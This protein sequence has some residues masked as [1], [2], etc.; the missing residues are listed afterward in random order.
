MKEL[1]FLIDVALIACGA[2]VGWELS[3]SPEIQLFKLYAIVG[4][5]F[6]IV[7]VL[8][9]TYLVSAN[10]RFKEWVSETLALFFVK[11]FI[12]LPWALMTASIVALAFFDAPSSTDL[13]LFLFPIMFFTIFPVF[14][15]EDVVIYKQF[16]TFRSADSRVKFLGG[17]FLLSGLLLQLVGAIKDFSV[18]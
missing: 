11:S 18:G 4:I 16:K 12:Y 15:F 6:D 3:F 2:Y 1:T 10:E 5:A 8:L 17:F 13:L 7:G 14:A 9:L